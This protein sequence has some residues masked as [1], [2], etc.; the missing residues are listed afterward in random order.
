MPIT[1]LGNLYWY[2]VRNISQLLER[3]TQF[4]RLTTS[5]KLEISLQ[6]VPM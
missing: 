6:M 1:S 2:G 5:Q 4:T 3:F